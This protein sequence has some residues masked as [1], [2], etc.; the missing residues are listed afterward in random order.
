MG[1]GGG[2]ENM[3]EEEK[4]EEERALGAFWNVFVGPFVFNK[5]EM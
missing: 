2:D 4:R 3:N 5:N 1:G